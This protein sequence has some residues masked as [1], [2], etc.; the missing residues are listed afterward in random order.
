MMLVSSFNPSMKN[1]ECGKNLKS[2]NGLNKVSLASKPD[3]F[4]FSANSTA[5]ANDSMQKVNE[6][7]SY[8][9]EYFLKKH[10]DVLGEN[11]GK[12]ILT[13]INNFFAEHGVF[14]QH[15]DRYSLGTPFGN[16]DDAST[17]SLFDEMGQQINEDKFSIFNMGITKNDATLGIVGD[18]IDGNLEMIQGVRNPL[19]NV[20]AP[21]E[22]ASRI[23]TVKASLSKFQS[24]WF[25][26]STDSDSKIDGLVS[27]FKTFMPE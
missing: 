24:E 10:P 22:L 5:L 17:A 18:F 13:P 20:K 12:Q 25:D 15:S 11:F 8:L 2:N 19:E 6:H 16:V 27:A 9:T 1:K 23:K 26:F 14:I 4:S 3:S 7:L 21:E